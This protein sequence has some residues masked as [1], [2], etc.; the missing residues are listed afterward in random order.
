[1]SSFR[2]QTLMLAHNILLANWLV[3]CPILDA[4]NQSNGFLAAHLKG[5]KSV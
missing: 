4:H 2:L 3:W 5:Q 1:M